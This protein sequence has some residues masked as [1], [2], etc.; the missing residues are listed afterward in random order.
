MSLAVARRPFAIAL[1]AAGASLLGGCLEVATELEIGRDGS[2]TWRKV[3]AVSVEK[4][5]PLLAL[6][7]AR[8]AQL[9]GE[10]PRRDQD[11]FDMLDVA[12]LAEEVADSEGV[13]VL[14]ATQT[15]DEASGSRGYDWH[16]AF[17]SLQ[18]LFDADAVED[19]EVALVR[20]KEGHWRL[21]LRFA[22]LDLGGPP[23]DPPVAERL[24]RLRVAL[25]DR[26][27]AQGAGLAATSIINTPTRIVASNGSVDAARR[28]A[29][30]TL[31]LRDL[32]D[33]SK[34]VWEVTF[35]DAPDLRLT[36]F[37]PSAVAAEA[38]RVKAE[39]EAAGRAGAPG[40]D[41]AP[42]RGADPK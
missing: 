37:P 29:S 4:A 18:A 39:A 23:H 9:E 40:S 30:W 38:A 41:A 2:G 13:R 33:P 5:R 17:D 34:L 16:V 1:L 10:E 12:E 32:A 36:A 26:L 31:G 25:L 11:P 42:R 7:A 15:A 3:S 8:T 28:R 20:T 27:A 14:A 6:F 22:F 19:T 35:E 21:T 24:T